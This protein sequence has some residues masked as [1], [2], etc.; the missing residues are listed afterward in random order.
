MAESTAVPES[1][2]YT[3]NHE[4]AR[5][6]GNSAVVGITDYAQRELGDITYVELPRADRTLG[7]FEEFAAIDSA[8]AS[9]DIYAPLSGVVSEVN[10]TLDEAPETVNAEPYGAGW[11]CRLS[12]I[13]P[14]E[15]D[16]LLTPGRYRELL[17]Q[18]GS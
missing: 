13:D 1:L 7:Q 16:N 17:E 15:M 6:E 2:R 14:A 3:E 9:T 11:I 12:E 10:R 4:W 5:V 8:K 18:L